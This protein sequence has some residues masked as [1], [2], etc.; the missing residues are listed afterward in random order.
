MTQ[1]PSADA[2]DT[3]LV[4]KRD[5]MAILRLNRPAALN[6][7][8][9]AMM[10]RLRQVVAEAEA[11]PEV[12]AIVVTGAGRGFCSGIDAQELS[13]LAQ[14]G[15]RRLGDRGMDPDLPAQFATLLS[16]T[17][18]VIAAVNGPAAGMGFV[19]A[20]MSDLRFAAPE[21]VFMTSFSQR[22]LIAEHATSWLL[23]RLVGHSTAL[24]LLWSSRRVGAE[25][26]LRI[27][28]AD[29]LT[30][31]GDLL[32]SVG[33]YVAQLAASVSPRS[34]AIIKSMVYRHLD[35]AFGPAVRDADT[36]ATQSLGHPD[37]QEG[38]RAFVERRPPVFA[39][40]PGRAGL[41]PQ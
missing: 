41:G 13:G 15:D 38:V 32:E 26:A 8:T 5:R 35:A 9:L 12:V 22:G 18:P 1:V 28:L 19:L 2:P 37:A 25:E 16:V 39:P 11:D 7:M 24:D 34:M 27:G 17:K 4:E 20:M 40:W 14:S 6:A 23:P 3:V 21:A 10:R 29:R 33:A 36:L 31:S 30:G